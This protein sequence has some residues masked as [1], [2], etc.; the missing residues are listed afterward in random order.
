M[1]CSECGNIQEA[2][3]KLIKKSM[4]VEHHYLQCDRCYVRTTS[5]VTDNKLRRQIA[6]NAELRVKEGRTE[7]EVTETLNNDLVIKHRMK[8]LTEKHKF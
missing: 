3:L 6:Y 4:G 5:Y 8:E 2:Q 1:E 7:D